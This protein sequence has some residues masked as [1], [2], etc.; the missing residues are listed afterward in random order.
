MLTNNIANRIK[1]DSDWGAL[2]SHIDEHVGA[3]DTLSGIDFTDKE[4]AAIEGRARALAKEKL[5]LI[6]EPF[7]GTD[8]PPDDNKEHLATKTGVL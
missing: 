7:F 8:T 5:E 3:L 6:L 4:A 1:T 2:K